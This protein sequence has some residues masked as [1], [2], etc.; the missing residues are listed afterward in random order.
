MRAPL[1]LLLPLVGACGRVGFAIGDDNQPNAATAAA[2]GEAVIGDGPLAY[3]RFDETAGPTATSTVGGYTGTYEGDFVFGV[4]GAVGD[5]SV[6]FNATNTRIDLGDVF[7]FPGLL[8]NTFET[9]VF[10]EDDN[11]TRFV[12][13]RKGTGGDGYNMYY[14]AD[15]L[16]FVRFVA[17]T[18]MSYASID[19]G[20]ALGHWQ[21]VVGVFDGLSTQLYVDGS[22]VASNVGPQ[23][24]I[25]DQPGTFV[26]G[27]SSPGQFRK[28]DGRL[29]EIAIY[30]YALTAGQVHAH[31]VASG[32][33]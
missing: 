12:L 33:E 21:H 18:E 8:P 1:L 29:D 20:P 5:T 27:D 13:Q 14:G 24:S 28:V 6:A 26:I 19:T 17:G 3:F 31:Y 10:S 16:I 23:A 11:N 2:Y 25:A 30:D 7:R 4:P 32:H 15:Y 9:W 22:Q